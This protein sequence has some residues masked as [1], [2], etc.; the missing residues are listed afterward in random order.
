VDHSFV[1]KSIDILAK[2]VYFRYRPS[3]DFF[4]VQNSESRTS[5]D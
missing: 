2:R 1:I 3:N 5:M 4:E